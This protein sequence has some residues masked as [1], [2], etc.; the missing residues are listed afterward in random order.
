ME[1]LTFL[2]WTVGSLVAEAGGSFGLNFDILDTNLV[3]LAIVLGLLVYFGRGFLGK[4]LSE[5]RSA[6]ET[7]IQEAEERQ[8]KAAESL[9]AQ[10][11]QLAQAQAEADR[12][13]AQAQ[14]TAQKVKDE[15]LA[16]SQQDVAR[17]KETASRDLASER[18]RAIAELRKQ[19]SE[20]ALTRVESRLREQLNDQQRRDYADRSIALLSGSGGNG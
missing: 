13:R 5:R 16:K 4:V 3:N 12:I 1:S 7:A 11:Q 15:V 14:E 6:I 10:Q 18:D 8:R 2:N 19:A 17:M 9:A 20:R